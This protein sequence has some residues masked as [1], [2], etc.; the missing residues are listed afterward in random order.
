MQSAET[1]TVHAQ[2]VDMVTFAMSGGG[3]GSVTNP[4]GIQ[5]Y[6][7]GTQQAITATPG[8]GYS[9]SSW[10][11]TTTSGSITFLNSSS[12]S[13]TATINGNGTVT[14][15]FIQ[16]LYS[17][18]FATSGGGSSTTSPTGTQS[19]T[20]N[21]AVP[22]SA[23]PASGYTFSN[24]SATSGITFDSATSASTTAHIGAAGTITAT[25]TQTKYSVSF[26][27]SG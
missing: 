19:Y 15:T 13:T 21:E 6:T 24:W 5:V 22:I 18:S 27:M 4:S 3:S 10:S 11:A 9:F 2:I 1:G 16:T 17:V 20:L 25:F 12:S 23:S 8:A 14:A 7:P 26:V